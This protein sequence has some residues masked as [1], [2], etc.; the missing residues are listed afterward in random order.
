MGSPVWV[1]AFRHLWR[2]ICKAKRTWAHDHLHH[3]KDTHDLWALTKTCKGQPVNTFLPLH[4]T[5]STLMDNPN[6]KAD[7]FQA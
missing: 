3:T 1:E 6:K 2:V 5:D 7:I 4:N